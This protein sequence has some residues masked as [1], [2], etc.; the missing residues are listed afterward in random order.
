MLVQGVS[1]SYNNKEKPIINNLSLTLELGKIYGLLGENGVGK[2]T[3]LKLLTGL[4][5]PN[6]GTINTLGYLP[7]KREP[8]FLS[9]FFFLSEELESPDITPTLLAKSYSPFYPNFSIVLYNDILKEFEID[10]NQLISKMSY[11]TKKKVWIALSIATNTPLLIMDEPTNGLDIPSKSQF[12]KIMANA[13]LTERCIIISTHQVRDLEF[14]MDQLIMLKNGKVAIN[15]SIEDIE[16]KLSFK[17]Y[18][19]HNI[20]AT[21]LYSEN[22]MGASTC[23]EANT[24]EY[25]KINL[26]LLFNAINK[27]TDSV[28]NLINS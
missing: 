28:I 8:N 15:S 20:P 13:L 4:I 2:S 12:R 1:F 16:N 14:L 5:F 18:T 9:S 3:L 19:S 7:S 26:E 21:A 27:N 23:I 17:N 22:I 6:S 10:T 11:G 25:T 24:G